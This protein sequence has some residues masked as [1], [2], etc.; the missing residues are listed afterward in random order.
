VDCGVAVGDKPV[1]AIPSSARSNDHAVNWLK[2]EQNESGRSLEVRL[3]DKAVES[4]G[5]PIG[6]ALTGYHDATRGEIVFESLSSQ[7]P[8][9]IL[10][11]PP[12]SDNLTA[13]EA[14][15]ALSTTPQSTHNDANR[16]SEVFRREGKQIRL[17]LANLKGSSKSDNV[18]RLVYLALYARELEGINSVSKEEIR[19]IVSDAGLYDG[20]TTKVYL[21]VDDLSATGDFVR[22]RTTGRRIAQQFLADVFDVNKEA[23]RL[24]SFT[25]R[26]KATP[27]KDT[28]STQNGRTGRSNQVK[29][30]SK[31]T[32]LVSKWKIPNMWASMLILC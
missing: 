27:A 1:T 13:I 20:N 19:L 11:L 5:V 25:K 8:Q 18:R 26:A 32:E 28:E 9:S 6:N 3:T 12:Q 15:S 31:V 4:F 29:P 30:S 17:D 2:Y 23:A 10:G 22:L 7:D 14:V 21:N 16:L 24:S